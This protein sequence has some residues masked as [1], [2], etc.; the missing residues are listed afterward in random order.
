MP[1]I[2][3]VVPT[4]ALMLP[5]KTVF[6][7]TFVPVVRTI[8]PNLSTFAPMVGRFAL[9]VGG[10]RLHA[11]GGEGLAALPPA[12]PSG[13]V[14]RFVSW[15]ALYMRPHPKVRM[16]VK[17][18]G[19]ALIAVLAA[20]WWVSLRKLVV[21]RTAPDGLW[22]GISEGRI[23]ALTP[24]QAMS[25]GQ[26]PGGHWVVGDLWSRTEWAFRYAWNQN[27]IRIHIPF[28]FLI[29]TATIPTAIAWHLDLV[30]RRR[31]HAGLSCAH[32]HYSLAGLALGLPCPECGSV[33]KREGGAGGNR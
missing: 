2:A 30:A 17:W 27:D 16:L 18:G 26:G 21:Y 11:D 12:P 5:T 24:P 8:V 19:L 33:V 4:F 1:T 3:S 10:I 32:C 15:Y 28:W 31:A 7:P 6:V 25:S 22:V 20:L 29:V 23:A 13:F 14:E 9:I